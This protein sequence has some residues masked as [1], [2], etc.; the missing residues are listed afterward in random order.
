MGYTKLNARSSPEVSAASEP[1]EVIEVKCDATC[2]AE[3]RRL[4][5]DGG[6]GDYAYQLAIN[7]GVDPYYGGGF[8]IFFTSTDTAERWEI[9]L[10]GNKAY[11]M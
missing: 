5:G 11:F 1:S 10:F 9:P 3:F 6:V 2:Q 4:E 8:V 7:A